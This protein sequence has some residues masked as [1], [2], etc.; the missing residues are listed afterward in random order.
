MSQTYEVESR[1]LL[2]SEGT[3]L[4][5]RLL[6][7]G[8]EPALRKFHDSLSPVSQSLFTPHCYDDPL[9]LQM[10]VQRCQRGI[11]RS[12]VLLDENDIV[13]GYFFLWDFTDPVPALGIGIADEWQGRQLGPQMMQILIADARAAGRDGIELTTV[14]S[15]DRAYALYKKMGFIY[16]GNVENVAGDGRVVVERKLFLPLKEGAKPSDREF[17]PPA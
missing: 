10:Y 15:N 16:L 3:T 17:R 14:L 11:D 8:D 9:L 13:I 2:T 5:A 6:A 1:A 7:P 12:Y 4:R